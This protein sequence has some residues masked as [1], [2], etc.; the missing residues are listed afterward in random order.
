MASPLDAARLEE[1]ADLLEDA[2]EY[3]L[4][5]DGTYVLRSGEDVLWRLEGILHG[6]HHPDAESAAERFDELVDEL[7]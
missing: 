4:I 3:E 5:D 1:L 2:D 6:E 7:R